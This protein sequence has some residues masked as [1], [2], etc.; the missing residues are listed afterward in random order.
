MIKF[1][2]YVDFRKY[3]WQFDMMPSLD[4]FVREI[5]RHHNYMNIDIRYKNKD[6]RIVREQDL[7]GNINNYKVIEL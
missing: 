5:V 1:H 3:S 2:P 7:F 4:Y 6:Y